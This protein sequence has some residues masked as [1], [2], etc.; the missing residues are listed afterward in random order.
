MW[1]FYEFVDSDGTPAI[2]E[3]IGA[4]PRSRSAAAKASLAVR[5]LYLSAAKPGTWARPYFDILHGTDGIHE[6]RFKAKNIHHRVLCCYGPGQLEVVMLT[7]AIEKDNEL[8]PAGAIATAEDRKTLITE[9]AHV[10]IY[11]F[12]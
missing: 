6:I 10:A 11:D 9:V 5:L 12:S 3:W 4:L 7:G 1:T 2:Q 8:E